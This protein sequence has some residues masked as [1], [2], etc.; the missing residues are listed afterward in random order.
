MVTALWLSPF[1]AIIGTQM[2][3]TSV[4]GTGSRQVPGKPQEEVDLHDQ[5]ATQTTKLVR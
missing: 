2:V 3:V 4:L 1:W 5:M